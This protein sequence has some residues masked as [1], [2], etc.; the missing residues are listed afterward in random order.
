MFILRRVTSEG[1]EV[2]TVLGSTYNKFD[3][4]MNSDEFNKTFDIY[5]PDGYPDWE[6]IYAFLVHEKGS[7]LIPLFRKSNY[8]VMMSD[9]KTFDNVSY[10]KNV[11]LAYENYK[12]TGKQVV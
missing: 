12:K 5:Y 8:Y 1:N 4:E 6:E 2:N 11:D 10:Y 3:K 7:Q 9:G